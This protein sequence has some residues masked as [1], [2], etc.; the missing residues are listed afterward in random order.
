[1]TGVLKRVLKGDVFL[2][3]LAIEFGS[4][5]GGGDGGSGGDGWLL[6]GRAM[7]GVL[8]NPFGPSR[9]R[10]WRGVNPWRLLRFHVANH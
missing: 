5:D 10:A 8:E 2:C 6:A 3:E 4:V 7:I 1:M 9:R